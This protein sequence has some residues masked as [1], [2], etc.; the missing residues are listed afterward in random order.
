MLGY[1]KF[2]LYLSRFGKIHG[3]GPKGRN[4]IKKLVKFFPLKTQIR[5]VEKRGSIKK[6]L[7]LVNG[8][9]SSKKKKK[10]LTINL[11]FKKSDPHQNEIDLR[12]WM[13]A[14]LLR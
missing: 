6:F 8:S 7:I 2:W 4:I 10:N 1:A 14:L 11:L 13:Y 3:F 12:H 5:I 9:S